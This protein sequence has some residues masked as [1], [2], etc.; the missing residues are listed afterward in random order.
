MYMWIRS[1]DFDSVS[2][3]FLMDFEIVAFSPFYH[4]LHSDTIIDHNLTCLPH[5]FCFCVAT[6][7]LFLH[8]FFFC[9]FFVCLLSLLEFL[10]Y[11][12]A[13]M[14]V[15]IYRNNFYFN[16]VLWLQTYLLIS[17]AVIIWQWYNDVFKFTDIL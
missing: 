8:L 14:Y 2:S 9:F 6:Y 10:S 13:V 3:I 16:I 4:Q 11:L 5:V 12:S 7:V 15:F 17:R 1:I